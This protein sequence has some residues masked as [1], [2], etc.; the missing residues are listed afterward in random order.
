MD[1][2]SYFSLHCVS[3]NDDV[4]DEDDSILDPRPL[5]TD[6]ICPDSLFARRFCQMSSVSSSRRTSRTIRTSRRNR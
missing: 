4:D 5:S 1:A 2:P 6:P 3:G